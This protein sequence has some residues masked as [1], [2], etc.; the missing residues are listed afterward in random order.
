MAITFPRAMPSRG[1]AMQEFEPHR[2]D[3]EAPEASGFQG[4]VQAGFPLWVG[5]WDLGPVGHGVS[6]EWRAWVASLRGAQKTFYGRDWARPFP[7]A[8][9]NG[10]AGLNRAGGGSFPGSAL[11]WTQT[12]DGEGVA[13]LQ[14]TGLPAAL[15]LS[16]GDYIGLKWDAGGDAAGTYRRRTLTRVLEAGTAN[17]SGVVTVPVE[18]PVPTLVVPGTALAH[19]DNPCCVMR[20][21]TDQTK[22]GPIDRRRAIKSG[23]IVGLQDLRT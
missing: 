14:L 10:F 18:P 1:A 6:D 20:Q 7:L 21:V 13:Y 9:I 16:V 15:A 17:G 4:G 11:T 5:I 8:H 2:V 12:I 19:L 3:Y 23:H 22:L